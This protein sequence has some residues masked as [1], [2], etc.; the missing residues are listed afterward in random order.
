MINL[1]KKDDCCGCNACGDVCITNAISYSIDEEGFWYPKVDLSKCINCN[2]CEKVCP[3]NN[4]YIKNNNID[5]L[6][7]AVE[8]K[9]IDVIFSSTSGGAFSALAENMYKEN[10]YV[11]GAIHNDDFSVSEYISKDRADLIK[12]RRSKD[13]QSNAVGF[14]KKVKELLDKNNKVLVCALP[15][16]IAGL[17]TYL[18]KDY[19]KLITVDLVCAGVNS[20]KVW[21]KY[22]DYIEEINSSKIVWTE[23]KSKEYGWNNL[24][25]KFIF[26]NGNE[27]FDTRKTSYFIKGYIESHLFC[28]PSCYNCKYK[29]FPRLADITI[30]DFWG[31]AK[32]NNKHNSDLGTSL[33]IINTKKGLCYFN[34]TKKRVNCEEIPLELAIDGNPSLMKSI[35]ELSNNRKDFFKDLDE[36][37]F[38]KLIEKYSIVKKSIIKEKIRSILK[39]LFILI[40]TTKLNPISLFQTIKY[41]KIKNI[42][43]GKGIICGTNCR[44]KVDKAAKLEFDGLLVF[45]RKE[46]FLKSKLESRLFVGKEA[47]LKVFGKFDIDADSEIIIFDNAELVI[48]G[49][50]NGDSDANSELNII[51]G[52]RIEIMSDVGIGRK[53]TI[54][55]TNGNSHF[56]NTLGYRPSRP[57]IIGEKSW[58]CEGCTIMPGVTI[59]RSAIVGA[60]SLVT[61]SVPSHSLVS[62]N[63]ANVIQKNIM[64]KW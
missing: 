3:S 40:K 48:H 20:P 41:S 4:N 22:L 43:H 14:Y 63:P 54:R 9:N 21:R 8:H 39:F 62:G 55:D 61:K 6:C 1:V 23:N 56:I 19:E 59:G 50:K 42:I 15:C 57:V 33:V 60:N 46:K 64:W 12:L 10:G 11:C 28:R 53:V 44:I 29:G 16:Q 18:G 2:K 32:Y 5:P 45:G 34:E 38:D 36:I 37:R 31:I 52:E 30:G 25:Q 7:Y 17:N 24:T 51:C 27:Y 26:E 35:S 58:L 49:G 47:S 13:L